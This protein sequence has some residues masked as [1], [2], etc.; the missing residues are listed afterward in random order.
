MFLLFPG[1]IQVE[2]SLS[3]RL[4]LPDFRVLASES[5]RKKQA[6]RVVMDMFSVLTDDLLIKILSFL[7][8]KDAVAMSVLSK[9]WLSLWT[10][11]PRLYFQDSCEDEIN[12]APCKLV[13]SNF[14]PGILLLHKSPFLES[15]YLKKLFQSK[16]DLWVGVAVDRFVRG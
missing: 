16:I 14:V 6:L 9:R 7:P 11:V 15:F 10:L 5:C 2:K 4:W 1:L 8:I 13:S 3:F 12:E